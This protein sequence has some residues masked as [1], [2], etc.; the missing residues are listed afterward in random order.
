M[1][2]SASQILRLGNIIVRQNEIIHP[3][4]RECCEVPFVGLE[5]IESNT[6]RRVGS[7]TIDLGR[8]NGRKPTFKCGQIVCGYCRSDGTGRRRH[9]ASGSAVGTRNPAIACE[10]V[11]EGKRG[12]CAEENPQAFTGCGLGRWYAV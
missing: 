6:G 2:S 4:D 9:A 12:R 10:A 7:T 11:R 8:L 3:G 5:H 1:K